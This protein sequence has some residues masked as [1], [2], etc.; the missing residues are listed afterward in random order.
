MITTF[1]TG[2]EPLRWL[3]LVTIVILVVWIIAAPLRGHCLRG[4]GG[5]A[6]K[7]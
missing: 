4:A 6:A 3:S 7:S 5:P 1:F 2:F